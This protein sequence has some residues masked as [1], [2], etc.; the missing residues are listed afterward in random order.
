MHERWYKYLGELLNTASN[1][2]EEIFILLGNGPSLA[3][4]DLKTLNKF[5][6]FG[7]NTAY[8]HMRK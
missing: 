2:K 4:V 5:D 7:L 3:D 8:K 1:I 6:T